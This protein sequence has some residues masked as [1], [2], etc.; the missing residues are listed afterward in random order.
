MRGKG[1]AVT[2]TVAGVRPVR[3]AVRVIVPGVRVDLMETRFMPH[4]V[5]RYLLFV[6]PTIP[7]L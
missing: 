7:E 3:R 1:A 4:S 6:E 5:R 2:C